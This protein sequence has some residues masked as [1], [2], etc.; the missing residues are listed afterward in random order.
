MNDIDQAYIGLDLHATRSDFGVID[1]HGRRRV[2]KELPTDPQRLTQWLEELPARRKY[3]AIEEGPLTQW[4]SWQLR[5]AVDT[6]TVCDPKE[7]FL[8]SRSPKKTDRVDALKLARLL[9]MGELRAVWHPEGLNPRALFA[10]VGSHYVHMRRRQVRLK[11]QIKALYR[12]WGV[13]KV[14]GEA[15][16]SQ[17]ERGRFLTQL[18]D[19]VLVRQLEAYYQLLDQALE[20]QDRA[21]RD[22]FRLGKP[23]PEITEFI[24][25]PGIGRLGAHLFDA[26]VQTPHRFPT[27]SRLWRW[28]GLAVTDRSS[29]GKPLGYQRLERAGHGELKA[30][31]YRGWK[32]GALQ[33]TQPNE[34]S[35]FYQRSLQRSNTKLAARLNT[36]RKI[37]KVMWTLWRKQ[38]RYDPQAF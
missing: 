38:L 34:V 27:I 10:Q 6:L 8:I 15:L 26:I 18:A 2:T 36:Q 25:I 32:A 7:N 19:P 16:Y 11:Q 23:Y 1:G 31:S 37:I 12:R 28:M 29:N 13:L 30:I 17:T 33:C 21:R 24:R 4:M 5:E 14:S 9:R 22:L 35:R 3:L 20:A